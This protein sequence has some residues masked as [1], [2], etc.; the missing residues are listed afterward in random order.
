MK[1]SRITVMYLVFGF[2]SILLIGFVL[3]NSLSAV[4]MEDALSNTEASV[5]GS[6]KYLEVYIDRIKTMSNLIAS[7][8]DVVDYFGRSGS[9]EDAFYEERI[10]ALIGNALSADG[11]LKSIILISKDGK[12]FSNESNL[13]MSMSEDMMKE[14][15]YVEAIRSDMPVLTSARMQKFSMDKDL[16]VISLSQ[17]IMASDGNNIGVVVIDIPYTSFEDYLMELHLGEDGYAFILNEENEVVFHKD[18]DYYIEDTL[19][20]ELIGLKNEK[21]GYRFGSDLL[22]NRYRM[23]NTDWILV[24]VCS[25]DAIGVIQ[26]QILET[27]IL[28]SVLL[29]VGVVITGFLLRK[30]TA[31]IRQQQ[32]DIHH[33]EM[34]AL[35]S[36]INP[37]SC[38]TRWIRLS[39]WRSLARVTKSSRRPS[40][41][42]GSSGYP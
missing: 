29:L 35:Y 27:V 32:Q 31:E 37:I 42:P 18:T 25:V 13:D 3:F 22:I 14:D 33:Y 15:W 8:R 20:R 9:E 10:D 23:E 19:K 11:S 26:R 16:W 4:M 40:P 2:L 6:G 1:N 28:G 24:G 30:L 41:L 5:S 17:E 34:N 12:I 7:D 36:Q 39:G 38:T 21:E